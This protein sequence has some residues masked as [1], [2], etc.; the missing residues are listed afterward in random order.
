MV[1]DRQL[2]RDLVFKFVKPPSLVCVHANIG[3]CGLRADIRGWTLCGWDV[4]AVDGCVFVI[5]SA[6]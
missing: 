4:T 3:G 1:A 6:V 5:L 2:D